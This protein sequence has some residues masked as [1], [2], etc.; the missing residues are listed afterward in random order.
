MQKLLCFG[1]KYVGEVDPLLM[2][3]SV[4]LRKLERWQ[5]DMKGLKVLLV[6]QIN[7]RKEEFS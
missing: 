3:H 7:F 2:V 6:R 1:T 5:L 4:I